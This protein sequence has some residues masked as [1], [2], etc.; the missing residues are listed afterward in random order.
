MP[1]LDVISEIARK[2][3]SGEMLVFGEA[4][5]AFVRAGVKQLPPP[6]RASAPKPAP[7]PS[8]SSPDSPPESPTFAGNSDSSAQAG[9]AQQAAQSGVPFCEH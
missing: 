6:D 7:P 4:R 9:A 2:L 3:E 8:T 5:P 1:D